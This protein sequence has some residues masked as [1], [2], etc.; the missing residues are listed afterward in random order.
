MYIFMYVYMYIYI[1]IYIYIYTRT[2]HVVRCY[3][4]VLSAGLASGPRPPAQPTGSIL[5][6]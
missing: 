6:L 4:M 5:S 2:Y 3:A 1:Y